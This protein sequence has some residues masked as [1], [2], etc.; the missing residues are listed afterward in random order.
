MKK[1]SLFLVFPFAALLP[2]VVHA[3]SISNSI[4]SMHNTLKNLF[5]EMLPLCGNL[6]VPAQAIAGFAAMFYI[7]SRVWQHIAR[8]E[9]IDFYPLL[10]PFALGIAIIIFPSIIALMNSIFQPLSDATAD[11]A[12]NSNEA[13]QYYVGQQEKQVMQQPETATA[14]GTGNPNEWAQYEQPKDNAGS[15][16]FLG[17][18]S[19]FFN[20]KNMILSFINSFLEVLYTAAGLAIDAIRT[21]YLIVLAIIGPI[22]FGLAVFDGFHHTLSHWISRYIHVFM[23]LPV[24]NIF[25]AISSRILELMTVD[26]NV[27]T[28]A[29]LVFMVISIIGYT[30]VPSVAGY[31]MQPGG[32][33]KDT[34]L[35]KATKFGSKFSP[36]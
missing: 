9:P 19:S 27:S 22:V 3:E 31:V 26:G 35:H 34:L 15:S 13:I 30:T 28:W 5:D 1:L 21:F 11:M 25:G 8:A 6:I 14:A 24:S 32:G 12:K 23:W 18:V 2:A 17:G 7:A 4:Y 29:Y 16:G 33:S 20:I 10:R 36:F